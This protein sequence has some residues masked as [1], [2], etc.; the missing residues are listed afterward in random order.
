VVI[1]HGALPTAH[2]GGVFDGSNSSYSMHTQ[3]LERQTAIGKFNALFPHHDDRDEPTS[4][5][6]TLE[7]QR[8]SAT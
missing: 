4:F 2:C 1:I 5:E 8:D 6:A 7:L 3:N